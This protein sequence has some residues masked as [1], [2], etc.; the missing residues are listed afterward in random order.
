M[1][2]VCYPG[3]K[4]SL[5]DHDVLTLFPAVEEMLMSSIL[6]TQSPN[7]VAATS[8][9]L[10]LPLFPGASKMWGLPT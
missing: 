2:A 7:A 9:K 3:A 8:T 1:A 4:L 6:R 10:G 5:K